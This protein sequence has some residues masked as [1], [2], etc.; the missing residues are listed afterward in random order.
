[1]PKVLRSST[2]AIALCA[3]I[4]LATTAAGQNAPTATAANPP[5]VQASVP[6]QHLTDAQRD[7][8]R[9]ALR[10]THTSVSFNLKSAK[11][12][13]SFEP[14]IGAKL[15]KAINPHPL[16]QPLISKLPVLKQ[17]D[18]VKFKDQVLIVNPMTKEI[19][20]VFTQG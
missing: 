5:P 2:V 11:S 14:A 12:A 1:M 13:E 7:Q 17:Y 10:G 9:A 3:A 15:P 8:V 20:D 18:Y 6:P 19:V 16:P 4:A